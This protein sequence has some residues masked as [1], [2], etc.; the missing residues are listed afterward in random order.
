MSSTYHKT[1][2][3]LE[4]GAITLAQVSPVEVKNGG[5]SRQVQSSTVSCTI[6]FLR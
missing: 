5:D 3:I 4:F 2:L 6:W 1:A